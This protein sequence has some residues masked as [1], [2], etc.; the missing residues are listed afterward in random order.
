MSDR[1]RKT[2]RDAGKITITIEGDLNGTIKYQVHESAFRLDGFRSGVFTKEDLDAAEDSDA[3]I[4][5]EIS[6]AVR[7][8]HISWEA[9]QE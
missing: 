3:L 1:I 6:E 9:R 7:K 4:Q 5:A 2:L 8:N